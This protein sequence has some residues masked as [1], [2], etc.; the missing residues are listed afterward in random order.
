MFFKLCYFYGARATE[1]DHFEWS[2]VILKEAG[3]LQ[4]DAAPVIRLL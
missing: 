4:R 1:P 3:A 2:R